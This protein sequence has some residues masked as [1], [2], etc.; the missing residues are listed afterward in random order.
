MECAI[1]NRVE[2]A[3]EGAGCISKERA[4][5][6]RVTGVGDRETSVLERGR[7][8]AEGGSVGAAGEGRRGSCLGGGW[9][10]RGS[11]RSRWR[12]LD[13]EK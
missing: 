12:Q 2:E 11:R 5:E 3:G 6:G 13:G 4:E 10:N 9:G 1:G 8:G 7:A